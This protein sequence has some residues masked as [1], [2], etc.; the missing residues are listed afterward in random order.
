MILFQFFLQFQV[1]YDNSTAEPMEPLHKC[2]TCNFET[3]YEKEYNMHIRTHITEKPALRSKSTSP[4]IPVKTP[5][6]NK[7]KMKSSPYKKPF[8]S[9]LHMKTRKTK[10]TKPKTITKQ[11]KT[12]IV[13]QCSVCNKMFPNE[14]SIRAHAKKDHG[15]ENIVVSDESEYEDIQTLESSDEESS[16][17]TKKTSSKQIK[18]PAKSSL[19]FLED[20]NEDEEDLK[21]VQHSNTLEL[22]S[23]KASLSKTEHVS[24]NDDFNEDEDDDEQDQSSKPTCLFC[25]AKFLSFESVQ[26]HIKMTHRDRASYLNLGL[27]STPPL[28]SSEIDSTTDIVENKNPVKVGRKSSVSK[29]KSFKC[30]I[31]GIKKVSLKFIKKHIQAHKRKIALQCKLCGTSFRTIVAINVHRYR[32]HKVVGVKRKCSQCKMIFIDSSQLKTHIKKVHS[33]P[34]IQKKIKLKV[35]EHESTSGYSLRKSVDSSKLTRNLQRS[36]VKK[37]DTKTSQLTHDNSKI[38]SSEVSSTSLENSLQSFTRQK[39]ICSLCNFVSNSDLEM[40]GHMK[41][42]N[43]EENGSA[44]KILTVGLNKKKVK[45]I[46][47]LKCNECDI[48]VSEPRQLVNHMNRHKANTCNDLGLCF[49]CNRLFLEKEQLIIHLNTAHNFKTNP[50]CTICGKS[51]A[52]GKDLKLHFLRAHFSSKTESL[53]KQVSEQLFNK[54]TT[55]NSDCTEANDVYSKVFKE[56]QDLTGEGNEEI[57]MDL[58]ASS[59]QYSCPLCDF[60]DCNKNVVEKHLSSHPQNYCNICKTLFNTEEA[61]KHLENHSI[62]FQNKICPD[63]D[64]TFHDSIHLQSH[65]LRIHSGGKKMYKCSMCE[66]SFFSEKGLLSHKQTMHGKSS[67]KVFSCNKCKMNFYTE[68]EFETHVEFAHRVVLNCKYCD[69]TLDNMKRLVQHENNHLKQVK[70]IYKCNVCGKVVKTL[71]ALKSHKTVHN[72]NIPLQCEVCNHSFKSF[73]ALREHSAKHSDSQEKRFFCSVCG[74]GFYF[75]DSHYR[76]RRIHLDP[77]LFKCNKCGERFQSKLKCL[78]HKKMCKVS[79]Q[80]SKCLKFY[81]SN[82]ALKKHECLVKRSNAFSK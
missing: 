39:Y 75:Y 7:K 24:Q 11:K 82:V 71:A 29:I 58:P 47:K 23:D 14:A 74:K 13:F 70:S 18:A 54:K 19:D 72:R 1:E 77:L 9:K 52:H 76:H 26:D 50:K 69:K 63:C 78:E 38:S 33:K 22:T 30:N 57:S 66:K 60:S 49:Y 17:D 79:T 12:K 8:P 21:N 62:D 2:S 81:N 4:K 40:K 20:W 41:K 80:C 25:N 31:C 34:V 5:A 46:S 27:K 53:I 42:H 43:I 56:L 51:Y 16:I 64:D 59:L 44:G 36:N 67:K 45:D 37:V 65:N 6:K 61:I 3:K 10:T 28:E 73:H 15:N 48:Y 68:K 35:V 55:N 32:C